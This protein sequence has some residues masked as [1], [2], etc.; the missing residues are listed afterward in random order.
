MILFRALIHWSIDLMVFIAVEN[1]KH[2]KDVTCGRSLTLGSPR[3]A[4]HRN[5]FSSHMNSLK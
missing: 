3:G 1:F 2:F 4:I 5:N